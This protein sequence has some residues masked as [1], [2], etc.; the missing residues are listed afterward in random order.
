MNEVASP[1]I[2]IC[3]INETTGLCE[4]CWRTLG[5]IAAWRCMD[6]DERWA[7]IDRLHGRRDASGPGRKRRRTRRRSVAS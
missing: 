2:S 1:C 4:G 7:V 3:T 5:E 6:S